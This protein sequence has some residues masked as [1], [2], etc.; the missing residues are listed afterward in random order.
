MLLNFIDAALS[1][2]L[3][4]ASGGNFESCV[5]F[6]L[7]YILHCS[8]CPNCLGIFI[9]YKHKFIILLT[10]ME[11]LSKLPYCTSVFWRIGYNFPAVLCFQ[12]QKIL[13][14]KVNMWTNSAKAIMFSNYVFYS[15]EA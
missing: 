9:N 5:N 7:P 8:P 4:L 1:R 3:Y 2:L 10:S 14:G 11:K 15:A 6:G 12:L 13:I